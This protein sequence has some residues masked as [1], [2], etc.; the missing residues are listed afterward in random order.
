MDIGLS[1]KKDKGHYL[2][3]LRCRAPSIFVERNR[4]FLKVQRTVIL[5][6]EEIWN[7]DDHDGYDGLRSW[8][9]ESN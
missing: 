3:T 4:D 7:A 1:R 9:G 5:M 8:K 6:D 2:D